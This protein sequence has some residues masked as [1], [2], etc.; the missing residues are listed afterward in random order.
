MVNLN[1]L[2]V[3]QAGFICTGNLF[4]APE[5]YNWVFLLGIK[6]LQDL[7]QTVTLFIQQTAQMHHTK[8]VKICD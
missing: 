7:L 1:Q 4:L 2:F 8:G 5:H 3:E 6:N